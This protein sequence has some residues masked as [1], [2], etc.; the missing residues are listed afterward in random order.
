MKGTENGLVFAHNLALELS[1]HL[2]SSKRKPAEGASFTFHSV[3]GIKFSGNSFERFR[4]IYNSHKTEKV[5]N[6]E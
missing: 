2:V 4:L 1:C 5:Q 3:G 6:M